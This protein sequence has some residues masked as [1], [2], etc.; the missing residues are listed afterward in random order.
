M[1]VIDRLLKRRLEKQLFK[2]KVLVITGARQVGKTTLLQDLFQNKTEMLW[3]N[4]DEQALRERLTNPSLQSLKAVIG[5][6]KLVV[7]DEVQ[8]I[9][10]P[11]LLLKLLVDNFKGV[12][13]VATGSSALDISETVFEPLTGRQFLFHL[14]PLAMAEMYPGKSA[15]EWEQALP[16]HLVFGSYPDVV[17]HK[18]DAEM[19]LNNLSDQYLYKDVL[20]WK[21]IRKPQLLESLL[22]LLAY[23]V[24]SEVSF[25][26]L[27]NTLKVKA[28]TIE[29]YVDL[30][31]KAFVIFRLNAYSKNPRKEVSKMSKVYFWDN[32]VR[33][34]VI[35]DFNPLELRNDHGKLWENFIVSER[36]KMKAYKDERM[37]SYFW[38]NYNQSEV[39]YLEEFKNELYGFEMKWNRNKEHKITRAF[40]NAYPDAI[41]EII[42]PLEFQEFINV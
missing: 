5:N 3:L 12:Q 17:N 19:I 40:T 13:F 4:A 24:C 8:R 41:T 26:E 35:N 22:K 7:I 42:T 28:E 6:Y 39:D 34:A 31:E 9:V 21:D 2:G 15:F 30:L 20:V 25:H 32:G 1:Q 29:N 36:M 27:A 23:Q 10:N 33:N 18:P 37:N 16:F 11:G 38:R 14:Y